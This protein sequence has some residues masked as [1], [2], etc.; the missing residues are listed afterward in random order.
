MSVIH[1]KDINEDLI[2]Y[3]YSKLK[4]QGDNSKRISNLKKQVKAESPNVL[5]NRQLKFIKM[6]FYDDITKITKH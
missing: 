2:F 4:Q 5:T 6:H 3:Q 1:L